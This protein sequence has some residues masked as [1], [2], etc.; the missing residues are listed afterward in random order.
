[1]GLLTSAGSGSGLDVEGIISALVNAERAPVQTRLDLREAKAQSTISALGSLSS[2]LSELKTAIE[3][4]DAASDFSLRK[5]SLSKTDY[6]SVTAASTAGVESFDIEVETLAT[7]SKAESGYITNGVDATF[8][9]GGRLT[10]T[11]GTKSFFVDVLATDKL[12][13][14]RNKI[15]SATTNIG[16]TAT[17]VTTAGGSKLTYASS[18]TGSANNLS[19]TNDNVAGDLDTISTVASLPPGT[20]MTLT[21]ATNANIKVNGLPATSST[22]TFTGVV[23]D[24]TINV[25]K[26]NVAS[27]T[28]TVTV[29][30]DT[31]AVKSA[32][33]TFVTKLKSTLEQINKLSSNKPGAQGPLAAD[34]SLRNITTKMRAFLGEAV[35]NVGSYDSLTKIGITSTLSGGV[36]LNDSILTKAFT[37]DFDNVVKLF[38]NSD[39]VASKFKSLI[40]ANVG[41]AGTVAARTTGLNAEIKRVAVEREALG[42]RIGKLQTRLRSQYAALDVIASKFK[43][44]SAFLSQNLS[45]SSS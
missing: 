20:P 23:S 6:V 29:A 41:S 5:V 17:I 40:D 33:A 36:E 37:E 35:A 1:M 12:S 24:L 38:T 22:N 30:K 32:I 27:E 25:L 10:F 4:L 28:T 8:G 39:G 45:K 19:V 31:S 42:L 14:I 15:N 21:A 44:T 9:T 16:V 13:D 26:A 43:G 7:G 34:G 3:K 11:A 2:S 18:I